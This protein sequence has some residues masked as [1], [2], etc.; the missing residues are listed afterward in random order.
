MVRPADIVASLPASLV[1]KAN[2]QEGGFSTKSLYRSPQK[3]RVFQAWAFNQKVEQAPAAL[4]DYVIRCEQIKE[5]R[6]L[7]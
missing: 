2:L 7:E 3:L 4:L 5:Q 6:F 1:W